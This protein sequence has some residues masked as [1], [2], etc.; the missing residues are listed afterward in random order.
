MRLPLVLAILAGAAAAAPYTIAPGLLDASRPDD[1][2]LK[3]AAGAE[4]FTI[5]RASSKGD[6]Y[7]NGVVLLGFKGSLYA[8]W[9]SSN[10]DEDA[11][12]T[13][14]VYAT[15]RDGAHW[16]GPKE[17][18]R[19]GKTITTSGGWLSDGKTLTAF[20]NVWNPDFRTGGTTVYITTQDG[21]RWSKPK[22]VLGIDKKPVP[23]VIEQDT[24]ALPDGRLITAFH[25]QP[26]VKV[27]PFYTDDPTGH[28]GWRR[29]KMENLPH[30]GL[31]SREME[32]SWFLRADGCLV[33]VFRDQQSSF[34]QLAS[35]SC[36][37]GERW[38]S[39]VVTAMPDSKA[40]QSAGNLP[41]GTAFLVNTPSGN[42]LRSPLVLSL[43][44]D[45]SIFTKSFVLRSGPLPP[46]RF[47]GLYK[48]PGYHY[49]KSV[50]WNGALYIGYA[51]GKEDVEATRV[52]ISGLH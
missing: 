14:V 10:K 23:G 26:G 51:T 1:L 16:S 29:G 52:P 6:T 49:P 12:D 25:L 18:S 47:D 27:A 42:K 34:R 30:E 31:E 37:R 50:L 28:T 35:Q 7:A 24:H 5:Y 21:V 20:I 46:V 39:P 44:K 48:R 8:Q 32:P 45:G 11:T 36:D 3:S 43:G 4:T 40:K 2:G 22:P 17:L 38:S 13:R 33:M 15:S 9:Q 19:V 41:D